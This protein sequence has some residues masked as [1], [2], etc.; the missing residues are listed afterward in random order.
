MDALALKSNKNVHLFIVSP[1]LT[2]LALSVLQL[3]SYQL[4]RILDV[5]NFVHTKYVIET[6]LLVKAFK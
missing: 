2:F 1:W 4:R 6:M 5:L 3:Q